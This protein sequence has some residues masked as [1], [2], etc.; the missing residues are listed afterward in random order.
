MTDDQFPVGHQIGAWV[1]VWREGRGLERVHWWCEFGREDGRWTAT[2]LRDGSLPSELVGR[3]ETPRDAFEALVRV[4]TFWNGG[5]PS[6]VLEEHLEGMRR[7]FFTE[8][9]SVRDPDL[10]VDK[11]AAGA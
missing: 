4:W 5:R 6:V 3:G 10:L 7:V 11:Q 9:G 2:Y 1:D 8:D